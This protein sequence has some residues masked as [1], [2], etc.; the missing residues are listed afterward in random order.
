MRISS[1][2]R[3]QLIAGNNFS[4]HFQA[5]FLNTL[6]CDKQRKLKA[7]A[8]DKMNSV[9]RRGRD[10]HFGR[11]ISKDNSEAALQLKKTWA[12]RSRLFIRASPY[13][14]EG[15]KA[16]LLKKVDLKTSILTKYYHQ[17]ENTYRSGRKISGVCL[18]ALGR[19]VS[20]QNYY[21]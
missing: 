9:A 15:G 3:Y 8:L 19:S 16:K 2:G 17:E 14:N 1:K 4:P 11:Q 7:L 12:L 5:N 13:K 18:A 10:F 21:T 6:D 20:H